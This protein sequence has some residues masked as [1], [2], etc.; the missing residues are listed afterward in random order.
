[1][2][3]CLAGIYQDLPVFRFRNGD[4]VKF[5]RMFLP[6]ALCCIVFVLTVTGFNWLLS[7]VLPEAVMK[8]LGL[9]AAF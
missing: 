6:D 8:P 7:H 5:T 2:C 4:L 9:W 3:Y 1:M